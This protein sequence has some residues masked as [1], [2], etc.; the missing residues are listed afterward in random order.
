MVR[1]VAAYAPLLARLAHLLTYYINHW[2]N[3]KRR[4]PQ[5]NAACSLTLAVRL[6]L[7]SYG[8][9]CDGNSRARENRRPFLPIYMKKIPAY[10][11]EINKH[12]EKKKIILFTW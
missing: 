9:Q 3:R 5:H 4:V 11:D 6:F 7:T 1:P 12:I 8:A 2:Q 10:I